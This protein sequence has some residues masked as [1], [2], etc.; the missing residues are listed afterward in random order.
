M[1]PT[2]CKA[3][4]IFLL[5]SSYNTMATN[6]M[7]YD[8]LLVLSEKNRIEKNY[9]KALELLNEINTVST[10]NSWTDLQILAL[11]NLGVVYME[12]LDYEKAMDYYLEG[13]KMA[14]AEENKQKEIIILNNISKIYIINNEIDK[15]QEYLGRAYEGAKQLNDTIRIGRYASNLGFL[16]NKMGNYE[17][18]E[19]YVDDALAIL[20]NEPGYSIWMIQIKLT[21]IQNLYLQK[22]YDEVEQQAA[23]I[24]SQWKIKDDDLKG[25]SL[26]YLAR[27]SQHRKNYQKAVSLAN[28]AL[29]G[30]ISLILRI[31]LYEFLSELHRTN[32]AFLQA[33]QYKDS[34]M[35]M[36]DSLMQ[37][38]DKDRVTNAQV[39]FDLLNSEKDLMENKAKQKE[40]RTLFLFIILFVIVIAG[41]LLWIQ[42]L[43]N[44]QQKALSLLE[45]KRLN[46]E[47]NGK[48]RQL[49]SQVLLQSQKNVLVEEIIDT[50]S[51]IP[52]QSQNKTLN[53]VIQKL[54]KQLKESSEFDS[55]FVHFEQ[56]NPAFLSILKEKHPDLTANDIR[57]LSYIYLNLNTKEI[58]SLLNITFESC[59]KKKQRLAF[60]MGM[61]TAELYNYLARIKKTSS[62]HNSVN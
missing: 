61:A 53:S 48:N 8:S 20:K 10:S 31:E 5:F 12:L 36:K 32:N 41:V 33:L 15:A 14:I 17:L 19:K 58:A 62:Y 7:H 55:F 59:K 25:E 27:I 16:A 22:K 13:Y 1:K 46:S 56:I 21:K 4:L 28:E 34:L 26:L 35:T 49:T 50:L 60:K 39:R 43:K 30:D 52:E 47:I 44:K 23:D 45:Q 40:E 57:L 37:M 6:R 38:N 2:I 51:N 11:N 54:K 18:G 24:L 3:I 9:V 42:F 29:M